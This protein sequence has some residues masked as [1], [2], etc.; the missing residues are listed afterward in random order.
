[1]KEKI[2]SKYFIVILIFL[3]VVAK[4]KIV[5][6]MMYYSTLATT[7]LSVVVLLLSSLVYCQHDV[8]TETDTTGYIL[9]SEKEGPYQLF[10]ALKAQDICVNNS[11]YTYNNSICIAQGMKDP[12]RS[13]TYIQYDCGNA[14]E[15]GCKLP[16]KSINTACLNITQVAEKWIT[17]MNNLTNKTERQ[18]GNELCE[19]AIGVAS[20]ESF[21]TSTC[22]LFFNPK[23]YSST[24]GAFGIWQMLNISRDL[25]VENQALKI[26]NGPLKSCVENNSADIIE[27]IGQTYKNGAR[28]FCKSEW[29]GDQYVEIYNNTVMPWFGQTAKEACDAARSKTRT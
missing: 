8:V 9:A 10:Q 28:F 29:T 7:T 2:I 23:A 14:N 27:G 1:M 3:F 22:P 20:G 26:W 19:A 18:R 5:Y 6:I 15:G 4:N 13:H 24:E 16:Q 11:K 12:I 25:S 17:A 21:G